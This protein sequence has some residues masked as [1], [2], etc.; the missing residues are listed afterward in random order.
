[1][2]RHIVLIIAAVVLALGLCGCAP[3]S[4]VPNSGNG[5]PAGTTQP[6]NATDGSAVEEETGVSTSDTGSDLQDPLDTTTPTQEPTE[7]TSSGNW[8][9]PDSG[10]TEAPEDTFPEAEPPATD[11]TAPVT[12]PSA[13]ATEP[14]APVTDPSAPATEPSVPETEAPVVTE[15]PAQPTEPSEPDKVGTETTAPSD[16]E[17]E[18]P[19][20][21]GGGI[22]LPDDEW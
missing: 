6:E 3:H 20:N 12:E 15:P 8:G 1:M 16:E 7:D 13:P 17:P 22:V 19:P 21:A 5:A 9:T 11:T 14:G 10:W 4:D 18:T 2:R